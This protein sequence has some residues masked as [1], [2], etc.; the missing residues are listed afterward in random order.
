MADGAMLSYK[1]PEQSNSS[2]TAYEEIEGGQT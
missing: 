1:L 2:K